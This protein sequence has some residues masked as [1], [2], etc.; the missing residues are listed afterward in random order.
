MDMDIHM[1]DHLFFVISIVHIDQVFSITMTE[2]V[3][4][5]TRNSVSD[6]IRKLVCKKI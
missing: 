1:Y 6:E 4:N 2:V 5:R 3:Q